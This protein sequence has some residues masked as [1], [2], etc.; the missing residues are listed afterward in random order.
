MCNGHYKIVNY[1]GVNDVT[2]FINYVS[3]DLVNPSIFDTYKKAI[4]SYPFLIQ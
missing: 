1:Q 2:K 4:H 3:H